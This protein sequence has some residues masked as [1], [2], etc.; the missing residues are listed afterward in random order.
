M[1]VLTQLDLECHKYKNLEN[2]I[3]SGECEICHEHTL[4]CEC[5]IRGCRNLKTDNEKTQCLDCGRIICT[6]SQICQ[7]CNNLIEKY[8]IY[9]DWYYCSVCQKN[10][11]YEGK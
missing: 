1:E 2:K 10:Y 8:E 6:Y 11:K 5:H 4:D 7:V 9:G 3:M